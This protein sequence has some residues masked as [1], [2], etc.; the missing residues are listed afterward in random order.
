MRYQALACDYDGTIAHDGH[1]DRETA[2]ALNRVLMSGRKLILVTGRELPEILEIFPEIRMFHRVVAENGGLI[3]RP[4]TE[5]QIPLGSP[6]P[7]GFVT[8]LVR[9][10]IST[11][12][13][14]KSIVA[15]REP[16]ESVVLDVIRDLGLE[17]QVIFNKGAVMVLPP[18]VNKA[19]GLTAALA[20]LDVSPHHVVGV[21][22]AENDHAFLDLCGYSV[23]VANAL[24][25]LK[26]RA[27]LVTAARNGQGVLELIE[28]LLQDNLDTSARG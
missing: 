13:V 28:R 12:S 23:A 27:N 5:E 9:R 16:W 18:G 11:L 8:E 25:A 22:D 2:A 6:P 4:A 7:E 26:E 20:E 1:V 17:L 24:P 15:T 3:Y 21:G 14:G 19:S 10:G